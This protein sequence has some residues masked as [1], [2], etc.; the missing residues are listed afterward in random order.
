MVD[1]TINDLQEI[2]GGINGWKVAAGVCGVIGSIAEMGS[3][4]AAIPGALG[5]IASVGV[6]VRGF[7]DD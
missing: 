2:D 4:V 3:G 5:A 6:I 7:E 1:L